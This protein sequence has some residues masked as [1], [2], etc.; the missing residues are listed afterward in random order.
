MQEVWGGAQKEQSVSCGEDFGTC[1][2]KNNGAFCGYACIL[3]IKELLFMR[4]NSG[5][6]FSSLPHGSG[7][8][9]GAP[10]VHPMQV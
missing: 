4:V 9:G 2:R 5:G 7:N 1:T 10:Q 6:A 3:H 8:G